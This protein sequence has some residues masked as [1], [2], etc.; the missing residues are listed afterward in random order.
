MKAIA[1]ILIVTTVLCGC[2][3]FQG[4]VRESADFDQIP[5]PTCVTNAIST[6][7]GISNVTYHADSGGRPIT[8]HG[9]E[10]ADVIQLYN[11]KYEGLKSSLWIV[12]R[13]D[14][15]A[16]LHDSFGCLN[17]GL[18]QSEVNRIYPAILQ[19]E[20]ALEAQCGMVGLRSKM[21]EHCRG[22]TC[23]GA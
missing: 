4:V 18:S 3:V 14:G 12:I 6:V 9:I 8:L 13:Y 23:G 1:P 20:H 21:R 10:K 16:T 2:E 5:Q 19:I 22:V 11:Y 7:P 15:H 17:C